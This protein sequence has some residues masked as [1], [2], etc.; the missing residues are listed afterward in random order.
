MPAQTEMLVERGL[1][2]PEEWIADVARRREAGVPNEVTFA[3]KPELARRMLRWLCTAGLSAAWV[4]GDTVYGGSGPLRAWLKEQRQRYALAIASNDGVDL[5]D[6][7]ESPMHVLAGEI[8]LYA[9]D[10]HE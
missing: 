6:G 7:S 8:A 9:R 10:P 5:P 4:T 2:L 3:T 1:Y